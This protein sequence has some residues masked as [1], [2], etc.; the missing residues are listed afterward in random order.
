[1][2]VIGEGGCR[3]SEDGGEDGDELGLWVEMVQ[4]GAFLGVDVDIII[5]CILY[6]LSI[7]IESLPHNNAWVATT[8]TS[9][10]SVPN[11]HTC[12]LTPR[13]KLRPKRP[14]KVLS[15]LTS[16]PQSRKS[17]NPDSRQSPHFLRWL[18]SAVAQCGPESLLVGPRPDITLTPCHDGCGD[19]SRPDP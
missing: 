14:L 18:V 4:F 19:A 5:H 7:R 10:H 16:L 13:Q 2:A 17:F 3:V 11:Q 8:A 12:H 15:I 6:F 9:R 1:M